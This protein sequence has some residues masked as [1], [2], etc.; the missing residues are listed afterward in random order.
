MS[1]ADKRGQSEARLPN[2]DILDCAAVN[3]AERNA[4]RTV[5]LLNSVPPLYTRDLRRDPV[6]YPKVRT[7]CP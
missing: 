5:G 6:E 1:V 2:L 7:A 3:L 4:M